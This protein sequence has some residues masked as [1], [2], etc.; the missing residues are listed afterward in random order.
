LFLDVQFHSLAL[1][2]EPEA[3]EQAHVD[4]GHPD[5]GEPRKQ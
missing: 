2:V 3:D 4:I 1:D 5:D